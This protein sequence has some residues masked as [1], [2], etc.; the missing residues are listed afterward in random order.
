MGRAGDTG[1]RGRWGGSSCVVYVHSWL[2]GGRVPETTHSDLL[3]L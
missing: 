3:T 1:K 2:K